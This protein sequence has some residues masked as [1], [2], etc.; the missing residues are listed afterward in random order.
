MNF[1]AHLYLSDNK[2][3]I[4][5]GNFIADHVKGKEMFIYNQTIQNGILLHRA[6]DAFTDRHPVVKRSKDRLHERYRHYDGVIIDIFYDHFLAKNWSRY[7]NFPLPVFADSFYKLLDQMDQMPQRTERFFHYMKMYNLL[8]NY[9]EID[10][11]AQV[12]DGM[13]RRSKLKSQM[14][15]AIVDLEEFYDDFEADFLV[16]FEDLRQFAT[17]K[18][19]ELEDLHS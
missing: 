1:L 11:I 6:I 5:I 13:N 17:H 7:S 12:L 4:M 15:L 9:R 2:D 19:T 18:L 16:F 10:T 3:D 14:H 8:V